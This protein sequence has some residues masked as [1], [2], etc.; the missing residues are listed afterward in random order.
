MISIYFFSYFQR[1]SVPGSNFNEI[2]SD[3]A[4]SASIIAMLGAIGFYLYASMQLFTG[5]MA[6]RFGA[7]RILL[8]GGTIMAL[9]SI[10]F[11]LTH[12]R[13]KYSM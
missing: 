8:I 12:N 6:D 10:L 5:I 11:P 1:I 7:G 4:A 2:Q 9:G 3:F 13:S